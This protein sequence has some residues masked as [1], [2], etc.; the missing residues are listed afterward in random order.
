MIS[1]FTLS[2]LLTGMVYPNSWACSRLPRV[3]LALDNKI[4][5]LLICHNLSAAR[6]PATSLPISRSVAITMVLKSNGRPSTCGPV[7]QADNTVRSTSAA[8]RS[9]LLIRQRHWCRFLLSARHDT[10]H[11]ARCSVTFGITLARHLESVDI[12]VRCGH[13]C[14]PRQRRMRARGAPSRV[15]M[16]GPSARRTFQ[17]R[18]A[19]EWRAVTTFCESLPVRRYRGFTLEVHHSYSILCEHHLECCLG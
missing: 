1:V 18:P 5:W 13:G 6:H 8:P 3:S 12:A 16:L 4:T 19:A 15:E 2:C 14:R 7:A 11:G 17:L 10:L 9:R